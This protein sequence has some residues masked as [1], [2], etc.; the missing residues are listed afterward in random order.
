MEVLPLYIYRISASNSSILRFNEPFGVPDIDVTK[1]YLF[2]ILHPDAKFCLSSLLNIFFSPKKG[3]HLMFSKFPKK[4]NLPLPDLPNLHGA[5]KLKNERTIKMR[6]HHIREGPWGAAG[7]AGVTRRSQLD[8]WVVLL[9]F[10][11]K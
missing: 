1:C 9:P 2:M 8:H 3:Y 4:T 5:H 7:A 11:S 10:D 6:L